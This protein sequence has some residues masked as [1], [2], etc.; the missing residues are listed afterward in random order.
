MRLLILTDTSD[1]VAATRSRLKKIELL[2]ACLRQLEPAEIET[3]VGY[4][5]GILRQGHIGLGPSILRDASNTG[6]ADDAALDIR[7]VDAAFEE[8]AA[9][10][11]KGANV[12]RKRLLGELFARAT[13]REQDFLARLVLGELRQGALEGVMIEAIAKA[14]GLRASEVR[15]AVM[16]AGNPAT[17]AEAALVEGRAGLDAFRLALLQ[18][19]QPMLAQTA[20]DTDA[21]LTAFGQA[22]FEYKLDG[23]RIQVHKTKT[24][25][26]VF[27]RRLNDVSAS[28]PEIVDR[29]LAL[30]AQQ[31]IL[32]G[33]VIALRAD[34]T[35]H[36]FQIT[37]RRFGRKREV[38]GFRESLPLSAF[39]FDCLH[40]NGED[41]ID[42]PASERFARMSDVLPAGLMIPRLVTADVGAAAAFL[43]NALAAG[44]EGL[45]A[46]S[47]DSVYEAGNR[48]AGWLKI[49][50]AHTL[51]LVVIAAEWGSG[52][53]RGSL[54]N[55]HLAALDPGKNTFVMLGKTFKGMTDKMLAWQT[56]RLLGLE[57][58]RE[59]HVVH[60]RPELVVEIAFN[61]LQTSPHYPG[62]MALRF[63]RVKRYREDKRPEDAD[64]IDTVRQIFTRRQS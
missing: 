39:F 29:V 28:V 17:V 15:R 4:L 43:D 37:M 14:A 51:D 21:A 23:A 9:V 32:D 38:D 36:P 16:L 58:G 10:S 64:T 34:G 1:A 11:G 57:I 49:K 60:V 41:L 42:R 8:M 5:T 25:V 19:V 30:S 27:T 54:S 52:R 56:S 50:P 45:M 62:G 59:G 63:A 24:A 13:S 46:K 22:A 26:R 44:H 18:P 6:A 20:E 2:Q 48:G 61:E 40:V 12:E 7:D 47:L 55:L 53:R 33:E 31:L 35:P 3:G